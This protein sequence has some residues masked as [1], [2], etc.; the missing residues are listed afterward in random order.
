MGKVTPEIQKL[1]KALQERTLEV[2]LLHRITEI[3]GSTLDLKELLSEIARMII[4]VAKGDSCLIYL[5]N[6]KKEE[7]I[8]RGSYNPHPKLL[9]M[10]S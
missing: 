8:L 6:E 3:I 5:F 9:G 4:G 10:L 7:L 1:K 2:N